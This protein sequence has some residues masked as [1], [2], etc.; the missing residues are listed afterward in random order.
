MGS[1][2]GAGASP[3]GPKYGGGNSYNPQPTPGWQKPLTSFFKRDPNAPPP[4]MRDEEEEDEETKTPKDK[5]KGKGKGKSSKKVEKEEDEENEPP[6]KKAKGGKAKKVDDGKPKR[7]MSAYFLW[8]NEV[9]RK[10]AKEKYPEA[11]ITEVSKRCGEEWK[12]MDEAT[13]KTWEKKQEE[14]KKQFEIDMEEWKNGGKKAK[15]VEEEDVEE[16]EEKEEKE[17]EESAGGSSSKSGSSKLQKNGLIS[18]S[19]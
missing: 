16:E 9:G 4:K 17:V 12:A 5:G 7:P 19:E 18:D 13:K 10:S 15:E 1:A 14:A 6:K 8:M 2:A 11:P 3:G